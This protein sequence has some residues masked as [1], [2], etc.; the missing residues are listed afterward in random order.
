M[1]SQLLAMSTPNTTVPLDILPAPE[2]AG[3]CDDSSASSSAASSEALASLPARVYHAS[4]ATKQTPG[5]EQ[6]TY[7]GLSGL[8][9]LCP[10]PENTPHHCFRLL[11]AASGKP[12]WH[13]SIP[14]AG[15]GLDYRVDRPFFHVFRGSSRKFGFLF[16]GDD[17]EAAE[18]GKQVL[19]RA[20]APDRS[21]AEKAQLRS[22]RRRRRLP[23]AWHSPAIISG[24]VAN[25]FVHVAHVG[26]VA[27]RSHS[28]DAF[29][30][31]D[32]A[33]NWTMVIADLAANGDAPMRQYGSDS[34]Q[35]A[36][37]FLDELSL[38]TTSRA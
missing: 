29:D 30:F 37:G 3:S 14:D 19:D 34:Q 4:F 10:G 22:R 8:L 6:W 9:S 7:S 18:F 5:A 15:A 1:I 26:K 2:S 28:L 12:I 36:K 11:D 21:G 17:K 20:M 23:F 35:I 16:T 38:S 25:S 32:S 33:D 13:F 31:Q 24:P 27:R